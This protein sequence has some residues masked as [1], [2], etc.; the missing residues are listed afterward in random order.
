MPLMNPLSLS[1]SSPTIFFGCCTSTMA[2]DDG[3]RRL[4]LISNGV[5]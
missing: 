3:D 2:V 4:L 1:L 5:H